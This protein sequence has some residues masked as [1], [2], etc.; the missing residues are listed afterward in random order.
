MGNN[1]YEQ[2]VALLPASLGGHYLA[3]LRESLCLT[4]PV[5]AYVAG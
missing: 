5:R 3:A 2:V 1:Q 4:Y